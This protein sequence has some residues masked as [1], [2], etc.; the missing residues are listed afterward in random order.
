VKKRKPKMRSLE[1]LGMPVA[2]VIGSAAWRAGGKKAGPAALY[3]NLTQVCAVVIW[4]CPRL[5]HGLRVSD[6][7]L[8]LSPTWVAFVI[9][10]DELAMVWCASF[11]LVACGVSSS[12]CLGNRMKRS[13]RWP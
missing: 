3:K 11:L 5:M 7:A 13:G 2:S 9:R 1:A 8:H 6:T 12:A 10:C 4:Q